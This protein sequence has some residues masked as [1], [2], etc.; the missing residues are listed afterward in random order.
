MTFD[1]EF[2]RLILE[3]HMNG[4]PF[5]QPLQKYERKMGDPDTEKNDHLIFFFLL[6]KKSFMCS[7]HVWNV[8]HRKNMLFGLP[9]VGLSSC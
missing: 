8:V 4:T 3:T 9:P 6:E 5:W 7:S 2:I 1:Y